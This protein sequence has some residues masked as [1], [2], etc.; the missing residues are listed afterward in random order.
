MANKPSA[1]WTG[2]IE[3]SGW[4]A[5]PIAVDGSLYAAVS[6]SRREYPVVKVHANCQTELTTTPLSEPKSRP[7]LI[8]PPTV[9]QAAAE[10]TS[11][12]STPAETKKAKTAAALESAV[13]ISPIVVQNY[14]P[15]CNRA[16]ATDEI[17]TAFQLPDK[18]VLITP[19]MEER[20]RPKVLKHL[21]AVYIK[22]NDPWLEVVPTGRRMYFF[23]KMAYVEEYYRLWA[24]LRRGQKLA[25]IRDLITSSEKLTYSAVLRPIIVPPELADG[26]ER[27]ILVVDTLQEFTEVK[28]T[29]A[30]TTLPTKEPEISLSA[31]ERP[32]LVRLG[33]DSFR[34]IRFRGLEGLSGEFEEESD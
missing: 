1:R 17:A 25:F 8:L 14:C 2:V 19:E 34:D 24:T 31:I 22:A 20:V 9:A 7:P 23:P 15:S 28:P 13:N 27:R 32:R 21:T 6:A 16:I 3:V 10:T 4:G 29:T 33:A 30:I 26:Q 5:E 12:A 11:E 18:F